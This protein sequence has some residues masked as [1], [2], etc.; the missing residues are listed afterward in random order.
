MITIEQRCKEREIPIPEFIA[1]GVCKIPRRTHFLETGDYV[2]LASQVKRGLAVER[3]A[4]IGYLEAGDFRTD[5]GTTGPISG[6]VFIK[7]HSRGKPL[8]GP[9]LIIEG[10]RLYIGP[11]SVYEAINN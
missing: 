1:F 11:G 2:V 5:R 8:K 9:A 3:I 10:D 6:N 7:T 4:E